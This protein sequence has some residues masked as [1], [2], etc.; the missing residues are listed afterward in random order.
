MKMKKKTVASIP[1]T[2]LH[3]VYDMLSNESWS[4]IVAWS[5]EGTE[6]VILSMNE[7][8]ERVLPI[9]FKHSNFS[10]FIRQL[11]I[12][13]FHK[14]H[15]S[16]Q[17]HIYHHPL[18]LQNRPDLLKKIQ[19]KSSEPS[20]P[21]I[22]KQ[23]PPKPDKS[24]LINKIIQLHKKNVTYESQISS[25]QDQLSKLKNQNKLLADQVGENKDLLSKIKHT[26]M[27]F[28]SCL[29]K[30]NNKNLLSCLVTGDNFLKIFKFP[31][32][33]TKKI[34]K[35][36]DSTTKSPLN[37][38]EDLQDTRSVGLKLNKLLGIERDSEVSYVG[39][40]IYN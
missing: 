32:D 14:I 10:S 17:E 16:S 20:S 11:N 37:T 28:A 9:Y 26:L 2:F 23:P 13:D 38:N 34:Q 33:K 31:L 19:R 24:P 40:L 18:F 35:L 7:F 30:S 3:K 6:F 4:S 1:T 36:E 12:Y 8:A 22:Q 29:K 27:F 39:K 15:S 21:Q 5:P 25:L